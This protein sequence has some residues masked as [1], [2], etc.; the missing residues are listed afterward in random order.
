MGK[1]FFETNYILQTYSEQ[2]KIG[3]ILRKYSVSNIEAFNNKKCAPKRIF[4]N[5]M[6]I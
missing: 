5:G 1:Y 6:K 3:L 2:K 4:F